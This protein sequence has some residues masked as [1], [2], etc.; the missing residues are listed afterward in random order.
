MTPEEIQSNL[1]DQFAALAHKH[2]T[3]SYAVLFVLGLV[4]ALGAVGGYIGLRSY[5]GQLA[6]AEAREQQY[7]ADR[8]SWQEELKIRDAERAA[9]AQ[10]VEQLMG[11]IAARAAQP[12]P[13]PIQTA[14][15]PDATIPDIEIGLQMAFKGSPEF[16]VPFP[17]TPPYV[18]LSAQQAQLVT[19]TKVDK[20]RLTEDLKDEKTIAGLQAGT[21]SS[22]NTDLTQCKVTLSA[23]DKVIADYK[24]LAKKSKWQKFLGGAKTALWMAGAAY[25]GHKL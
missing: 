18:P 6:K 3:V 24:K 5:E 7:D 17:S 20:D 11:Q 14:L 22:L 23:S 9:D 10:R 2:A 21:I 16:D 8:K 13:K 4:L 15:K 19:Q 25:V 12:L 1:H